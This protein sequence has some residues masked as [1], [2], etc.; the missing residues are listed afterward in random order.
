MNVLDKSAIRNCTSCGV[1]ASICAK[2]A[3]T[4]QLDGNGFYRPEIDAVLC[5][6]CGLCTTTCYKFD[7]DVKLTGKNQLEEKKLYA[8]WAKDDEVIRETTSGGIG[9]ILAHAIYRNGYKVVGVVYNIDKD[10]A[11]HRIAN[12]EDDLIR[13]RGS[14]YIQS[15]TFDAF[16]EIV[17]NCRNEK[18]AV[19]GTPCQIY[20]LSKMAEKRHA[21]E[22]FVLI[23]IY[24]HGCPSIHSWHKYLSE[25]KRRCGRTSFDSISFRSKKKGWGVYCVEAIGDNKTVYLSKRGKDQFY[26]LFFSDYVLNDSCYDC[27]F[28]SSLE[29]CDI[30]LGDFWGKKFIGN[31]KGVSAVTLCTNKGASLFGEISGIDYQEFD[32]AEFLPNQGWNKEYHIS[33]ANRKA[34]M[35]IL[36]T[37]S[38]NIDEVIQ[39]LYSRQNLKE[40]V[41]R[42][43]KHI[44]YYMPLSVTDG[45]KRC[46][47]FMRK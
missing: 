47:Y 29:Y 5:N 4:M 46:V 32:I 1:C 38:A 17:A 34:I 35:D 33:K 20:A 27:K 45:I 44:L 31:H 12:N 11:E 43:I 21:R 39:E 40:T 13:F 36:K 26:E 14:K 10:R 42:H 23:D 9:D 7:V 22:N 37:E 8:A 15:Y 16:K 30:R 24:C 18:Y 41:I 6:D 2:K 3:I 25:I 28:R 19:F